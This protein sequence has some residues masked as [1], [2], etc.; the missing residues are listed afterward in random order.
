MWLPAEFA[1]TGMAATAVLMFWLYRRGQ[2]AQRF[3]VRMAGG[4]L[5]LNQWGIKQPLAYLPLSQLADVTLDTRSIQRVVE[6]TSMVPAV[7]YSEGR[8]APEV[9][10]ARIVLIDCDGTTVNMGERFLAH[11]DA[12]DALGRIRVFLRSHGWIPEDERDM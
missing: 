12:V 10:V 9:D 8:T 6:G 11:T 1:L 4:S 7:R 5:S 2:T 3:V